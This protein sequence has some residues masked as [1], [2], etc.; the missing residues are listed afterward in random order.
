[1]KTLLLK[2]EQHK[3]LLLILLVALTFLALVAFYPS[4]RIVDK[5]A[6]LWRSSSKKYPSR[7]LDRINLIVVHHSASIG[8]TAQDYA[9][10]HVLSK[11]WAA[12]GYH[13]V[14]ERNGTIIQANPLTAISNHTAGQNSRSIGICLSGDF[15]RQKPSYQQLNSLKK[16]IAHLRRQFPQQ[17]QVAGHRDHGQT[18]CPGHHLYQQLYKF[19]K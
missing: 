13:F 16:L 18:S 5:T 15:T 17:L 8:Q 11:G 19:K 6:L 3:R 9:R 14:I 2:A 10:Y 1:M 4:I 7:S 12:I